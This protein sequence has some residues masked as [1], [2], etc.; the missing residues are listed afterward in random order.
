M[1]VIEL[2]ILRFDYLLKEGNLG[3]TKNLKLNKC[4]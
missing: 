3:Y 1:Y 4:S 2:K